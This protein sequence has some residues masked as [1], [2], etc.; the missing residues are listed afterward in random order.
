[1]SLAQ[2]ADEALWPIDND[3]KQIEDVTTQHAHVEGDDVC[4]CSIV[5]SQHD[6]ALGYIGQ[7]DTGVNDDRR[8]DAPYP[9]KLAVSAEGLELERLQDI[10]TEDGAV[11]PGIHQEQCLHPR[12]VTRLNLCR[13]HRTENPIIA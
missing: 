7:A 9:A 13:D 5:P 4:D 11:S 3:G 2:Q 12:T 6:F 10:G 1:M 8:R